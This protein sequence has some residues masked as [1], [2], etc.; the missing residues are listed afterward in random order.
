MCVCEEGKKK[1]IFDIIN[2]FNK[3]HIF[4]KKV[5]SK[6]RH[7]FSNSFMDAIYNCMTKVNVINIQSTQSIL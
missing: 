4:Y 5:N 6:F 1:T 3:L 7:S 2:F